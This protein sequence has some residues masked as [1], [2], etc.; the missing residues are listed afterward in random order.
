MIR[1]DLTTLLM[2]LWIILGMDS[3]LVNSDTQDSL[4]LSKLDTLIMYHILEPLQKN[5]DLS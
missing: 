2:S 4:H 3:T 1:L 5:R